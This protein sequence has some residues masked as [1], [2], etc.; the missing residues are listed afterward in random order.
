MGSGFTLDGLRQTKIDYNDKTGTV[1]ITGLPFQFLKQ[2][3]T[4]ASLYEYMS[5]KEYKLEYQVIKRRKPS[6]YT[7]DLATLNAWDNVVSC[8]ELHRGINWLSAAVE[9]PAYGKPIDQYRDKEAHDKALI[10]WCETQKMYEEKIKYPD[11]ADIKRAYNE[12][13]L[14]AFKARLIMIHFIQEVGYVSHCILGISNKNECHNPD[15]A[16]KHLAKMPAMIKEMEAHMR[17]CQRIM[18][19]ERRKKQPKTQKDETVWEDIV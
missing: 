2:V 18:K 11:K 9:A 6:K 15:F 13:Y 3:L 1:N 12:P 14:S 16:L 7:G 10:E 19:A 8:E 17:E 4:I 5:M